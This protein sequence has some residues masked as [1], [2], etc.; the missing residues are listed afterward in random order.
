MYKVG[1]TGGIGSGKSVVCDIFRNLDIP[2]YEADVEARRIIAED[3]SVRKEL[4]D[5]FGEKLLMRKGWTVN[6]WQTGSSLIQRPGC[7]STNWY[8]RR[9]IRILRHGWDTSRDR[10]LLRKRPCFLNPGPGSIWISIYLLWP[11]KRSV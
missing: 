9:C 3:P 6:S 11:G 2:V 5:R 7:S 8:I 4:I 1:V 10:T